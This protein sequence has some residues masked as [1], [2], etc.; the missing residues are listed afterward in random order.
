MCSG[1]FSMA[2]ARTTHYTL[3]SR[4]H[5]PGRHT[6]RTRIL[7][8]PVVAR[9]TA[10]V[11]ARHLHTWATDTEIACLLA[12]HRFTL[13]DVKCRNCEEKLGWRYLFAEDYT[14]PVSDAQKS[15]HCPR[16][17][18]GSGSSTSEERIERFVGMSC[19]YKHK[20]RLGSTIHDNHDAW[21]SRE[22]SAASKQKARASRSM[23]SMRS[24]KSPNK[25]ASASATMQPLPEQEAERNTATATATPRKDT[26]SLQ[27]QRKRDKHREAQPSAAAAFQEMCSI[28]TNEDAE[29]LRTFRE[30]YRNQERSIQF[31]IKGYTRSIAITKN[32]ELLYCAGARDG[33]DVQEYNIATGANP[34]A[35]K[36]YKGNEENENKFEKEHKL[37]CECFNDDCRITVICIPHNSAHSVVVTGCTNGF[38]TI[39]PT[40]NRG[41]FQNWQAHDH[42][43]TAIAMSR[44][45]KYI[46]VGGGEDR[47]IK[48]WRAHNLW[49]Q[50]GGD[51]VAI[52]GAKINC[53][54]S[55]D[56]SQIDG[57][58][59]SPGV[60]PAYVDYYV[61]ENDKDA[62]GSDQGMFKPMWFDD[63]N[64][65]FIDDKGIHHDNEVTC[66]G[67]SPRDSNLFI[68][69]SKDSCLFMWYIKGTKS[70]GENPDGGRADYEVEHSPLLEGHSLPVLDLCM[71]ED[72]E[73]FASC[74]KDETV[75]IWYYNR[76]RALPIHVLTG[77]ARAVTSLSLSLDGDILVSASWDKTVILWETSTGS[78]LTRLHCHEDPVEAVVLGGYCESKD[79]EKKDAALGNASDN[80][81]A[82][83]SWLTLATATAKEVKI[84]RISSPDKMF[85]LRQDV[86]KGGKSTALSSAPSVEWCGRFLVSGSGIGKNDGGLHIWDAQGR[87]NG[88]LD[89]R[90]KD[91]SAPNH[92]PLRTVAVHV[93]SNLSQKRLEHLA[94]AVNQFVSAGKG[95]LA[96]AKDGSSGGNTG[97]KA[98]CERDPRLPLP[99]SVVCG[100]NDKVLRAWQTNQPN[101]KQWTYCHDATS[102]TH[103]NWIMGV[104]IAKD[105]TTDEFVH[106]VTA[107]LDG[108][109]ALTKLKP[110][111]LEKVQELTPFDD[112]FDNQWYS[113]CLK[114]QFDAGPTAFHCM[115]VVKK[116]SGKDAK[117]E[118][119][120]SRWSIILGTS[121]GQLLL[122]RSQ[123]WSSNDKW[124]ARL[125]EHGVVPPKSMLS[126]VVAEANEDDAIG[127]HPEGS[128]EP[129]V[130]QQK[131]KRQGEDAKDNVIMETVVSVTVLVD[132]KT[133]EGLTKKLE[134]KKIGATDVKVMKP[135]GG[136]E[137]GDFFHGD[138]DE[139]GDLI[140]SLPKETA[141]ELLRAANANSSA[142]SPLPNF[143]VRSKGPPKY[144]LSC[145]VADPNLAAARALASGPTPDVVP[146]MDRG[147][148]MKDSSRHLLWEVNF[149]APLGAKEASALMVKLEGIGVQRRDILKK[150]SVHKFIISVVDN[151]TVTHHDLVRDG[152]GKEFKLNKLPT[153]C[154]TIPGVLKKCRRWRPHDLQVRGCID[155]YLDEDTHKGGMTAEE[156]KA[157]TAVAADCL[158]A[159][160]SGGKDGIIR[161][162]RF[163]PGAEDVCH[164]EEGEHDEKD[165]EFKYKF[166]SPRKPDT[167]KAGVQRGNFLLVWKLKPNDSALL[168][169]ITSL[170]ITADCRHVLSTSSSKKFIV[171]STDTDLAVEKRDIDDGEPPVDFAPNHTIKFAS[172]PL[173]V[174]LSGQDNLFSISC[175]DGKVSGG[176]LSSLFKCCPDYRGEPTR[177]APSFLIKHLLYSTF[178]FSQK[179]NAGNTDTLLAI[180]SHA[181]ERDQ[182]PR[183]LKEN[184]LT[185]YFGDQLI[186]MVVKVCTSKGASDTKALEMLLES[187]IPTNPRHYS[188][189]IG[190]AIDKKNS[191]CLSLLLKKLAKGAKELAKQGGDQGKTDY[192]WV[193]ANSKDDVGMERCLVRMSIDFKEILLE[194]LNDLV[195]VPCGITGKPFT[196]EKVLASVLHESGKKWR[197]MHLSAVPTMIV[198]TR[199][200]WLD[201]NVWRDV[202]E[203]TERDDGGPSSLVE[204]LLVPFPYLTSIRTRTRSEK[205]ILQQNPHWSVKDC[206]DFVKKAALG[207]GLL[208]AVANLNDP[209]FLTN[210]T[211]R[212]IISYKWNAF[213]FYKFRRK[214]GLYFLHGAVIVLFSW[215]SGP[216]Y[217]TDRYVNWEWSSMRQQDW[218]ANAL[219]AFMLLSTL[220]GLSYTFWIMKKSKR[221]MKYLR[222]VW[223]LMHLG[224]L[225]LELVTIGLHVAGISTKVPLSILMVWSWIGLL[226]F[227][228]AFRPTGYLV[229]AL[230]ET[231]HDTRWFIFMLFI[232]L[233]AFSNCFYVLLAT[234]GTRPDRF[235]SAPDALFTM[236][237]M[238]VLLEVD[239]ED[240]LQDNALG[241]DVVSAL[242]YAV[243]AVLIGLIVLSLLIALMTDGFERIQSRADMEHQRLLAT[244]IL[245]FEDEMSVLERKNY[246]SKKKHLHVM[247]PKGGNV[248]IPVDSAWQGILH[249]VVRSIEEKTTGVHEEVSRLR[250]ALST[251]QG[252]NETQAKAASVQSDV[253]ANLLR[254]VDKE[255]RILQGKSDR[256]TRLAESS[257]KAQE[258]ATAKDK[259]FQGI[260]TGKRTDR[261]PERQKEQRK[262]AKSA[263]ARKKTAEKDQEDDSD[264]EFDC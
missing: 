137:F 64:K 114:R 68:S 10:D 149:S 249:A 3:P 232:V 259:A 126:Y 205:K 180:A 236:F 60:C 255:L 200:S 57:C 184:R 52:P 226:Y 74:S 94:R 71:F 18:D 135:G 134:H 185:L 187:C 24:T 46:L 113:P 23:K 241:L 63:E 174:C 129:T 1:L 163:E 29:D 153:D 222:D 246:L 164:M 225:G 117:E 34:K 89:A 95:K 245:D 27:T 262:E 196:V 67:V 251:M 142:W 19:L 158:D 55:I 144:K 32:A 65:D 81:D 206:D 53:A 176:N 87:G 78:M 253:D 76:E 120:V 62:N 151:D 233:V 156:N 207:E 35:L 107:G 56:G 218:A 217:Q 26:V 80:T 33:K 239:H 54:R 4:A 70:S 42:A 2:R 209:K 169:T 116:T 230:V 96:S 38:V 14:T 150:L 229:R 141:A 40:T 146:K 79:C 9:S 51:W 49:C 195:L 162:W 22:K 214:F 202:I 111:K 179:N 138:V 197:W 183:L 47:A 11:A 193:L 59:A 172:T 105:P 122:V 5:A 227:F 243:G 69:G 252:E 108:K 21:Q 182:V 109:V 91:A 166:L 125:T 75:I 248:P 66:I 130:V 12:L 170:A 37:R 211:M 256:Y 212:S 188:V 20:L 215:A 159:I 102:P 143:L 263:S 112:D 240:L 201:T 238:L 208:G 254:K 83:S 186:D 260:D 213:G 235:N 127:W 50:Q 131:T 132:S 220:H 152:D 39:W 224:R 86:P 157:V 147:N 25:R 264:E 73:R 13:Q 97:D 139:Q 194:F 173:S 160:V 61:T 221:G 115:A 198:R 171:W 234:N 92:L 44:D 177:P 175:S 99:V 8:W 133:V 148:Q 261:V 7:S 28:T 30:S 84:Q 155:M 210:I 168:G 103:N 181:K 121:G 216:E 31:G 98:A 119:D 190:I 165:Y 228:Q 118:R 219:A 247:V 88:P 43:I 192:N 72:G 58:T 85:R 77:H 48:V 104:E 106:V 140:G 123:T 191:A 223:H 250:K 136:E 204:T 15:S 203:K 178:E 189:Y 257:A 244:I 110:R 145:T 17:G 231:I 101:D 6:R 90:L 237:Q 41:I 124:P 242:M 128:G 45:S 154:L 36:R 100:G 16:Y 199:D 258:K 82:K 93:E 161:V 167:M